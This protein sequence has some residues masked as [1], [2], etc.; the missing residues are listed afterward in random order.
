MEGKAKSC[1]EI[2]GNGGVTSGS[3]HIS[4]LCVF[5]LDSFRYLSISFFIFY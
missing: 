5:K 4:Y 3:A 2:N 1:T